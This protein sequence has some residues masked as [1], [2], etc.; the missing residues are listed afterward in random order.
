MTDAGVSL[1]RRIGRSRT[2]LT[3][4]GVV[5]FTTAL[6]TALAVRFS[7]G[8]LAYVLD[9]AGIHLSIVKQLVHHGTWGV[10]SGHFESSS[11]SPGWDLLLAGFTF[12]F[13]FMWNVWPLVL[14]LAAGLWLAWLFFRN[15]ELVPQNRPDRLAVL[16]IL[17]LSVFV[18]FTPALALTGMEHTLHAALVVQ[19]LVL[20]QWLQD[21]DDT[22]LRAVAPFYLVLFLGTLVRYE[23]LFVAIGC[24][25][26][27]AVVRLGGLVRRRA[28]LPSTAK[29]VTGTLVASAL[30]VV[31]LGGVNKLYGQGFFPNSIVEK[32][33][34][35]SGWSKIIP[36]PNQLVGSLQSDPLV[37][38]LT[39]V[40][41]AYVIGA[42]FGGSK[43]NVTIAIAYVVSVLL[44]A[45]N[46]QFGTLLPYA[47][48]QAYLVIAGAFVVLRIAAE[49]VS[50]RARRAGFVFGVLAILV[51]SNVRIQL[52]YDAS[53]ASQNTYRQRYQ[54]GRF[55]EKY[56]DGRTVA[57]GEL[58][59]VTLFHNG[60]VVDFFGLGD[61][62]VLRQ[63]RSGPPKHRG[64]PTRLGKDFVRSLI[65]RRHVA[66]IGIYSTTLGQSMPSEWVLTGEW[67]L[68]GAMVTAFERT[69]QFW[70]PTPALADELDHNLRKF[71]RTLPPDVAALNRD[72]INA[73]T[74]QSL[75]QFF[76]GG[77]GPGKT[78]TTT[79]TKTTSTNPTQTTTR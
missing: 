44:H 70:A 66:V 53:V 10:T 2:F 40:A 46:A 74:A 24:A 39:L 5:V 38:V 75:L 42:A 45:S 77:R 63:L 59:Y 76:N 25:F 34:L 23:T 41:L 79:T 16:F 47:R 8:H 61:H 12:A 48:Y 28:G 14:N 58:G 3:S 1:R 20:L 9:D 35:K 37:L 52:T 54:L 31:L 36:V 65:Q 51:L 4:A 64:D 21:R 72:Q 57:T 32:S 43:R 17:V 73:R 6:L 68:G 15:Q 69:V 55:F 33:S 11:S 13:P 29:I 30:P 18:L 19:A 26:A 22:T 27:I 62:E 49:V 67:K 78:T 60:P 50:P 56:Y 71:D 7:S